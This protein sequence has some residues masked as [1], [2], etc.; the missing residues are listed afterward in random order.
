V[1]RYGFP[2]GTTYREVT[3]PRKQNFGRYLHVA[4][5]DFLLLK[6]A[7]RLPHKACLSVMI[8]TLHRS[9]VKGLRWVTLPQPVLDEWGINK[10]TKSRAITDLALAELLE[11]D[12]APGRTTR[13]RVVR[14]E[15]AAA[16][17]MGPTVVTLRTAPLHPVKRNRTIPTPH[18]RS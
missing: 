15:R 16:S 10:S 17:A 3:G 1:D 5:T 2:T 11:V 18:W 9:Q 7:A 6:R 12:R 4:A 13:V 14:N 8:L